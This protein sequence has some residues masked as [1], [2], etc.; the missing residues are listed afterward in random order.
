MPAII[1]E[2]TQY[3]DEDTG[4]PLLN[5]KIFYGAQGSDPETVAIKVF[6]DR[7]L[8]IEI[9][10]PVRTDAAGRTIPTPLFVQARY[11]VKVK[12]S[13]D[14]QKLINLDAGQSET[15]GI[16]VLTNIAGT[17]NAITADADPP[18]SSLG[19][20]D[21]GRQFT[22]TAAAIN[23]DNM[24]LDIGT[25]GPK[26]IKFNFSEEMGPGFVQANSTL[27]LT[28]NSTG[29][30]FVWDNDG[31]GIS[32][33]TNVAGG[34]NDITADGGPSTT[35]YVNGQHYEFK[36]SA[37]NTG[38]VTLKVGALLK[39]SIK[40][41]GIELVAGQLVFNKTVEVIY[42]S[43]GTEFELVSGAGNAV[44]P[45]SA[46]DGNVVKFGALPTQLVDSLVS[47]LGPLSIQ[48][49][50]AG[51]TWTRP[52]NV[53]SVLIIATGSGGGGEGSDATNAGAGGGAGAT[54]IKFIAA[55]AAMYTIAIG[56]A[57]GGGSGGSGGGAGSNGGNV[58]VQTS[59]VIALGGSG[60]SA[61]QIGGAGGLTGGGVGDLKI[62]GGRGHDVFGGANVLGA[63]G[64]G[65]YWGGGGAATRTSTGDSTGAF[66]SGGGGGSSTGNLGGGDGQAGVVFFL[67][68]G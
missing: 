13:T 15:V 35:G 62:L 14:L 46:T 51:G 52:A 18:I 17:G 37:T 3:F 24:T 12:T 8:T 49:F 4:V 32:L 23:T 60:A 48:T 25:V 44:T 31:R 66:G 58:T 45:A 10:Q 29:D 59:V 20:P 43:T 6:Q 5:A 19:V 16:T 56:T 28:Y 33:L 40:S 64:G 50:T 38:N 34:G 61:S 1:D 11:S 27:N 30:N 63:P 55:A 68:F 21:N 2:N 7:A 65:S 39:H 22:L 26:A 53:K 36:P 9:A 41:K 57:G 54:S 67:E 42:N 47:S